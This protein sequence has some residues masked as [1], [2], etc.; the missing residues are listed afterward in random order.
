[1]STSILLLRGI[2]VGGAGKLPMRELAGILESLGLEN[3]RTYIQSG[4]V[5]FESSGQIPADLGEQIA[6]AIEDQKG[7]RPHVLVLSGEAFER[8][9]DANP[10]EEAEEDPSRVHLFFLASEPENPDVDA[11]TEAKSPTERFH[12]TD[13]VFY[14]YAPDGIGRS[15]LASKAEK[16]LGVPA[17]A[18]NWRTVNKLLDMMPE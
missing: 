15:K 12:L 8:A 18:R 1:M 7:F 2:N 4:N 10:F 5:V 9:A 6:S 13:E 11:L 17:T 3:I 16:I 14:L